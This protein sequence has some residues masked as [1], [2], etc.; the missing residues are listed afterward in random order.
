MQLALTVASVVLVVTI[1]VGLCGYL[2]DR[3]AAAHENSEGR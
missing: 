3:S 1:V 2:I